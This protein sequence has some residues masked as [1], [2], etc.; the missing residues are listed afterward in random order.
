MAEEVITGRTKRS[1][2]NYE[3]PKLASAFQKQR[4]KEFQERVKNGEPCVLLSANHPLEFLIAM[5]IPYVCNQWFTGI[6]AAKQLSGNY[7]L[8]MEEM[9]YKRGLCGYCSTCLGYALTEEFIDGQGPYGGMPKPSIVLGERFC[10]SSS[11]IMELFAEKAGAKLYNLQ[12]PACLYMPDNWWELTRY[13]WEK[14][15][16]PGKLDEAE[17]DFRQLISFLEKESGKR[18]DETKLLEVMHNINKQE[19]YYDKIRELIAASRPTPVTI[20]D[21]LPAVMQA[22]WNRGLPWAV[23]HAKNFYEEIKAKADAGFAAVPNERIRL[24]WLGLG[25]WQ[26]LAFYQYFEEKYG[27]AF[28]WSVYLAVAA[29]NYIRYNCD[30][31]PIRAVASHDLTMNDCLELPK[32][33]VQWFLHEFKKADVDAVVFCPDM[34]CAERNVKATNLSIKALEDA[35]YPVLKIEASYLDGNLWEQ[36][37]S[38]VVGMVEEFLE[39][40]VTPIVEAKEAKH[41]VK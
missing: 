26:N 40:R 25:F 33:S 34:A 23:E 20:P 3:A 17:E 12:N 19:E 8:K 7:F 21:V 41:R 9:G 11:K 5:D 38:I 36:Q 24:A 39:K 31:N 1:K 10:S 2:K 32:M 13:D 4:F 16:E 29:D 18:F 28:V 14:L 22:Q 15:Y 35:G 37:E 6:C 30:E 27:A